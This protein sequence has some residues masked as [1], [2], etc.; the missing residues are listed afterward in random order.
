MKW[1]EIVALLFGGGGVGIIIERI[2][3]MGDIK[4][5]YAIAASYYY[6]EM[7]SYLN[8]FI[9]DI[10]IMNTS[11]DQKLIDNLVCRFFDGSSY[12]N[13]G[14]ENYTIPPAAV[15]KAR[16]VENMKF[17]LLTYEKKTEF[18]LL[19][20]SD[21]TAFIEITYNLGKHKNSYILG[22]NAFSMVD[23]TFKPLVG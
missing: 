13:L 8:Y 9:L 12:K 22:G 18:P 6:F 3:K 1:L 19:P 11:G 16:A 2:L 5:T 15:L 4:I 20:V 17:K 23:S 14:F 21:G 10:Q 7:N